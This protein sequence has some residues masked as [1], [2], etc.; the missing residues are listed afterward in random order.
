MSNEE[1]STA[2]EG[3]STGESGA[4]QDAGQVS[5]EARQDQSTEPTQ[6]ESGESQ[7][8]SKSEQTRNSTSAERRISSRE[9]RLIENAIEKRLSS[10]LDSRLSPLLERLQPQQPS[11]TQSQG[12]EIDFNNLPGSIKKMVNSLVQQQMKDGLGKTLPQL[13]NEIIGEFNTKTTRQEAR[14]YLISQK[15]IGS[16]AAI[17]GEIQDIIANDKLLYHSVSEYP[18]EVMEEAIKRWRASKGNPNA[19]SKA[20]LSTIS[21]GMGVGQRSG[22]GSN[23]QKVREL[24]EKVSGNLTVEEQQKLYREIENLTSS[25]K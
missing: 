20:E 18:K 22:G 2:S 6:V 11:D 17:H 15:D 19:P 21:G 3:G 4:M 23:L 12:D 13:K 16:N 14:N 1:L 9:L 25:L 7:A 5:Q 8:S 24:T 10:A